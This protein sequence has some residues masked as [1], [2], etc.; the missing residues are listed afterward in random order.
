MVVMK[1]WCGSSKSERKKWEHGPT[2]FC[3]NSALRTRRASLPC[4]CAGLG[5][6]AP[7]AP[8]LLGSTPCSSP[9]GCRPRLC[10]ACGAPLGA[11]PRFPTP[12][13][14]TSWHA[15]KAPAPPTHNTHAHLPHPTGRPPAT[16]HHALCIPQL[17]QQA[18]GGPGGRYASRVCTQPHPTNQLSACCIVTR[19]QHPPNTHTHTQQ[20]SKPP[21]ARPV[22]SASS[23]A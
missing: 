14:V 2:V 21:R 8:R 10:R 18:G 6:S 9:P 12:P 5:G 22:S 13:L 11:S 3:F 7:H 23:R 19:T 17:P 4:A 1:M 20:P 16:V 15:H